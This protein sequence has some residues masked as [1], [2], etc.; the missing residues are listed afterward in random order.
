MKPKVL[1]DAPK[2]AVDAALLLDVRFAG[3]SIV[4]PH[5]LKLARICPIELIQ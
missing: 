5:P 1:F 2:I 3:F 4:P